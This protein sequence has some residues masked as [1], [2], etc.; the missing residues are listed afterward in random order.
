LS[1]PAPQQP[2]VAEMIPAIK[3]IRLMDRDGAPGPDCDS[4]IEPMIV[5]FSQ[6]GQ[7]NISKYRE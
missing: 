6:N 3:R 4:L 1:L 2:I 7:L 5:L